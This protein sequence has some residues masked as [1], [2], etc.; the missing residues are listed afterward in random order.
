VDDASIDPVSEID[1]LYQELR[2]ARQLLTRIEVKKIDN[3][4]Y[5]LQQT[6]LLLSRRLRPD[7]VLDADKVATALYQRM[8]KAPVGLPNTTM[9][10]VHTT[11]E[12]VNKPI[13]AIYELTHPIVIKGM[14][15][16]AMNLDRCL[17]MLASKDM[18]G[19]TIDLMGSIS[20]SIIDNEKNLEIYQN[21]NTDDLKQ[22]ISKL[23]L[24]VIK[25]KDWK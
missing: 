1:K 3:R 25:Q 11:N 10:L 15:H 14:D 19:F 5:N 8:Q 22:L 20:S 23:F 24:K 6:L 9:G 12:A 17:F 2:I 4:D 18:S 13:F 7:F 21:G 16:K